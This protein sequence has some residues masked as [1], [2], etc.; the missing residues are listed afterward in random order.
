MKNFVLLFLLIFFPVNSSHAATKLPIAVI[1]FENINKNKELDWISYGVAETITSG[2]MN[3]PGFYLVERMQ[4]NKVLKE[5]ALNLSGVIGESKAINVGELTG[6]KKIVTGSYQVFNS[7]IRLSSRFISTETSEIEKTAMATG[8]LDD[9]FSLQDQIAKGLVEQYLGSDNVPETIVSI[10]TK[11]MDAFQH[12]GTGLLLSASS[13]PQQAV[14]ELKKALQIDSNFIN[15]KESL[16]NVFWSFDK[17]NIWYYKGTTNGVENY[18]AT[19]TLG[20]P[21]AYKGGTIT[22]I[23]ESTSIEMAGKTYQ[24]KVTSYYQKRDDGIYW[25][26]I[27]SGS[28]TVK[29]ASIYDPPVLVFPYD[30]NVGEKW[31]YDGTVATETVM[32][33]RGNETKTAI[34]KKMKQLSS[35]VGEETFEIKGK[36]YNAYKI[37]T[38]DLI[39][40][41]EIMISWYSPGVG[42]VKFDLVMP[43]MNMS[44][45]MYDFNIN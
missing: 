28:S 4:L 44:V 37:V 26:K 14:T 9:I 2:L 34:S 12:Y 39:E 40:N 8:K 41:K 42:L 27:E 36:L 23:I 18:T 1:P 5:Q 7:D 43:S 31:E 24:D 35:I 19:R 38:T 13:E 15:A 20:P 3:V 16:K 30:M 10:P 29:T 21:E 11:S 25:I 45:S 22:P 17:D 6:A 32:S 33:M